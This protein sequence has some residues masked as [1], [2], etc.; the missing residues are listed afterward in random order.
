MSVARMKRYGERGHPCL[1]NLARGK[2]LPSTPFNLI[3]EEAERYREL[4]HRIH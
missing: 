2:M 3:A 1:T 4:T